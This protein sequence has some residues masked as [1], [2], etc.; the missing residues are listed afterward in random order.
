[1]RRQGLEIGQRV[2]CGAVVAEPRGV[3][4]AGS[5]RTLRDTLVKIA[6]DE[7]L[8]VIVDLDRLDVP[9]GSAYALFVSAGDQLTQ[10]PGVPLLLAAENEGQ[11]ARVREYHLPRFVIV[12]TSVSAAVAAIGDPPLRRIA[13]RRLPNALTSSG[14]ARDFVR[15][16]CAE[17]RV[18]VDV[19]TAVAVVAELVENTLLHTYCA[20]SLRVELRRDLLTVAVYDD[21][22]E[23]VRLVE[24]DVAAQRRGGLALVA[25]YARAWGCAPT[26]AGG[27]VVWAT[28]RLSGGE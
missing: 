10:W 8:A 15:E 20:P 13:R 23:P 17:W 2:L 24:R 18:R 5:Y 4:D 22:P 1:V 21:D 25:A 6:V 27:K 16:I 9:D 19:D 14:A 28:L 7:P 11:R 12:H 3:L 26:P